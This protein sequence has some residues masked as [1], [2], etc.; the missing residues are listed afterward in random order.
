MRNLWT[1]ASFTIKEMI[2][3][4]SFLIS[5]LIIFAIIILGF[6]VPNIID[7]LKGNEQEVSSSDIVLLVDVDN[8]YEGTLETLNE[9]ELGK[10]FQVQNVSI[11]KEELKQK[12]DNEE[13]YAAMIIE[14]KDNQIQISYVVDN[15]GM[16]EAPSEV[17]EILTTLY[18]K[19]QIGKLGLTQEQLVNI[20][21]NFSMEVVQT[22][23]NPSSG[24][25]FAIMLLSLVLF[26]AI[27]FCA[28]QVSSS[29]TTEKTSKIMETLVTMTTPKTI[30]LGKTI[31][32][33]I[34]G[35]VQVAAI[36]VVSII[37]CNLFLESGLLSSI[38]DISK[39]TPMLAIMVVIY[40][41]F[42]YAIYSLL[43]A[44]TGST[45]SKPED[46]NSANGPVAILAVIG[47]YLSY[48][49]MMNPTSQIN[50]FA[51]IFPFS[52]PFSMP[53]RVMMGTATM[54]QIAL[55]LGIM[56]VSIV[57]IASISIKIYSSAI[58][59]Y[60]T[61]MS[62]KDIFKLYKDKKH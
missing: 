17:I 22:N 29:I 15:L 36:I 54:G 61:K 27:Y 55:S 20:S 18:T 40:F 21:P 37:S 53:F 34:V 50:I 47:F 38:I 13:I 14:K 4:K 23:E 60:G 31:G 59:N 46:I 35:L 48:F 19:V 24:N 44:L 62:I 41:I 2:R 28:Y 42:G 10:K 11:T 1:V 9:M 7:M 32:I 58:L 57:I 5:N 8:L 16:G 12:I 45:V 30:V 51:S 43:Y 6:N 3:R 33:G 25:V 39:I 56:V 49:S 26:Y 52:A